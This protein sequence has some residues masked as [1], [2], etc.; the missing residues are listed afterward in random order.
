[1]G[2]VRVLRIPRECNVLTPPNDPV[3]NG[4]YYDPVERIM[5]DNEAQGEE[6]AGMRKLDTGSGPRARL[7]SLLIHAVI[8]PSLSA[9]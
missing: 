6:A 2:R 1:M 8:H 5:N 7:G 4:S 9:S 3:R